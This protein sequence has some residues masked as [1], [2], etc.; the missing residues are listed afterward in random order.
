MAHRILSLDGGGT[1]ALLEAMALEKIYGDIPG[2][3]ILG[4]FD[5]V[6]AN[7]G[8][9][10]VLAGLIENKRPSEII[11]LFTTRGIRE[12]IFK[13]ICVVESLLAHI[14]IFPKYS[15]PDK[16]LGLQAAFGTAGSQSLAGLP[17]IPNWPA[18]PR[19]EAVKILIT[20][21]DYDS[22]RATF[23]RSYAAGP[24][25]V[26]NTDSLVDCVHA[27][28]NAPVSYFNAPA[29]F[30]GRRYW[31]G[32][33]AGLNNPLMAAVTEL[34]AM[35]IAANAI[36][37][38]SIGTGTVKLLP[39]A[40]PG[41]ADAN[42]RQPYAD[43]SV[44]ADLGTA[45]RCIT[46]DPPDN[47]S[48]TAHVILNNAPGWDA[49]KMGKVVRLNPVIRPVHTGAGWD[50][51]PGLTPTQFDRLKDLDMDAVDA[52]DV[53]LLSVLGASWIAGTVPNQPIR[54]VSDTLEGEPGDPAFVGG[55]ARW[56][57]LAPFP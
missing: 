28:S 23:F 44:I 7:S 48:Y 9:S 42:L 43:S 39:A 54:M 47:A 6:A 4:Q 25:A 21:F 29:L 14:P 40:A 26:A 18:G 5:L 38:L 24:G 49:G 52:S 10:I 2:L 19:G 32:A 36:V 1:W 8:G 3:D 30:S 22:L 55:A 35:G 12:Q 16:L 45:A 46:D 53:A 50:V 31:D 41:P 13:T 17:N 34:L 37:A 27:S 15:A 57:A 56:L 33:M 51:P 11:A 20:S